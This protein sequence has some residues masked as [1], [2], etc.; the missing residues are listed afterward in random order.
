MPLLTLPPQAGGQLTDPFSAL[1]SL[2]QD[3]RLHNPNI[4]QWLQQVHPQVSHIATT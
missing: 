3:L 4:Q 2:G 1:G